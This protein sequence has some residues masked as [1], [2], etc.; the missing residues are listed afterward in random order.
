MDLELTDIQRMVR[1]TARD[2]ARREIA[3]RAA[4]IDRDGHI[5]REL[6]VGLAEL[7]LMGVNVPDEVGGAAAGTVAYSLA[8]TE[9]ARACA[10]TAVTMAVTNMVGEVIAAFGTD[11]QRKRYNP[12]ICAGEIVGAF[13]LSEAEAGSDAGS[14]TTSARRDGDA[15][16]LDGSKQWISHADEAGVIVIWARTGGPGSRGLSC[17]LVDRDAPGLTVPRHEEK[18]G[19]NGSHTCA[20]VLDA[21][22]VPA[23]ALLGEE[24]GGFRVAMMAL[25]GGRIG[26]A[27]QAVG[28]GE[29]ALEAATAYAKDRK[30]FGSPIADFQA[31]Q[32]MIADSRTE[33]DAA[34]LLAL[35]AAHMKDQGVRFSKEASMAK[36][37]ASEAAWRVCNRAVQI[38]GGYGY[39]RE[40]AVERHFRDVRVAQIY[41]G[42]SE[43]QRL[44]ISRLVLAE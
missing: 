13:G 30:Q 7:G 41:E 24:G 42:T 11:A 32:W 22:R 6:L 44:V 35:R 23:G 31:I 2:F 16:V 29:A 34:R 12:R 21:V 10:S 18:M 5:P 25:D 20:V 40:L 14:M 9:V 27:S 33:L 28:I 38:H 26:I 36:L 19:L 8:L 4:G 17:F 15:W 39:T 43:V 37:F 1:D 3:P